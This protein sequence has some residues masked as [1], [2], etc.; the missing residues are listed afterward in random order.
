[1]KL[2]KQCK[3]SLEEAEKRITILL[4]DGDTVREENFIQ[5]ED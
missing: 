2:A 1:M 5:E 3:E 4:K